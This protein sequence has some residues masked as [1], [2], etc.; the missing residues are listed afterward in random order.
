M[1]YQSEAQLEQNLI[2]D[3]CKRG[4]EKVD[5]VDK[6]TLVNN[7]RHTLYLYN[8]D[9]LNNTPFTDKEFERIMVHLEGKTV[10]QSARILRDK[11][12]LQREDGTEVYIEFFDRN[13]DKNIYQVTNQ[14]TV[15]GRYTN[16][17]DVTILANGLPVIQIEL[18]RRGLDLKEAFNQIERYRKHSYGGLYRYIQ[19]FVISNGVDTKYFANSDR[20]LLYS[21]T[22]F[23]TDEANQRITTLSDF[24]LAFLNKPHLTKMIQKYMVVNDTDKLLMVLRPYQVFAVEALVDRALNT[25]KDGYNWHTTG[26]GKTLTSFKAS[27]ILAS[28][29]TIKK[30]FFIVDR[31]D[32]DTQTTAEFNKFEADS[33]D[34]TDSTSKLVKQIKDNSRKLIVT[35]IQ[36][37]SKAINSQRYQNVMD[38]YRN[39]KVIFIIDECHRSQFGEMH[40]AIKNHFAKAQFFGFTGTPRFKE[41]KSQDDRTT[42]DIFGK[43]LHT[44]LIKEA[45]LDNNVLGFSVEYIKTFSGQYDENDET[46]VPGI[47]TDEVF[48][49]DERISLV[50]NHIVQHHHLKTRDRQ[51]TAIF[52]TSSIPTLIK[53]YDEFKTINH[54]LK[55]AAIYSFGTNEE[56][57]GHDEHS[58]DSLERIMKDYNKEFGT[59]FTTDSFSNYNA[60]ISK[61]VKL[62][63]ID[64]LIVVNMYL[65]GF[66]SRPLNTLYVD[67]NLKYHDLLQAFSRT[68]RVEK[69]TKPYGNIVCYRN[70]KSRTD[71]AIRLFS[72]TDSVDE[73]LMKEYSYYLDLFETQL[74]RVYAIAPTYQDVDLLHSEDEQKEFIITFR[75]LSKLLLI[76]KSFVEFDFD[77]DILGISEQEYQDFKSKYLLIYDRVR[78]DESAKVSI[79]DDIDFSIELMETN[80][81][82]VAYIMNLI[83]NIDLKD[84][85]KK[86]KDIANI[87][88]EIDRSDNPV[89]R[90]KAELIKSF[91]YDVVLGLGH[92]DDIDDAFYDFESEQRLKEISEFSQSHNVD[93]ELIKSE[94][95]EYEFTGIIDKERIRDN[96]KRPLK[97]L[98]KTE[99]LES[100]KEFIKSHVEKYQ[101]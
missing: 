77:K 23:W 11:F 71:E 12:I 64:I 100:I 96:I 62:A 92:S 51:Y 83:R 1:N 82:N 47:N 9:K 26:S 28:E 34:N 31:R 38:A 55:I 94:I 21:L 8:Q 54:G 45:I 68:N 67:K 33:V 88:T 27:Q 14:V 19:I 29:P 22:F 99:L 70:L 15:K 2:A 58:R 40:K 73:V 101:L 39:E 81:I 42:A 50:A 60:D 32:L 72:Q 7:F 86:Q 41:N 44:Y 17:Y 91:L 30:V 3:L 95:S 35:T 76:L 61:R 52:A 10:Y 79:L 65:T 18:K 53:Y 36:K 97:L 90:K 57:E 4:F 87:I 46:L 69:A 66:D 98:E 93:V 63:Q 56:F 78:R 80:R 20:D 5:I 43:C 74:S 49:N 48:N 6:D 16:R 59:N 84:T 25:N 37:M 75:E 85:H 24:S 89:L 13:W